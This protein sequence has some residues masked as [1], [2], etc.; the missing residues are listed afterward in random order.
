MSDTL[1]VA[2][3]DVTVHLFQ[4]MGKDQ[5]GNDVEITEGANLRAGDAVDPDSLA[6]YQ[7]EALLDPETD[8]GHF[9][10]LF[11]N[12]SEKEHTQLLASRE[13][14]ETTVSNADTKAEGDAEI[15]ATKK[16]EA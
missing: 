10:S 6:S 5:A 1:L 12:M 11:A 4:A 9:A 15:T 8:G 16:K 7:R 3:G 14:K 13:A 2:R